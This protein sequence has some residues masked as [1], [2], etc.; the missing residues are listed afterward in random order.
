MECKNDEP[1]VYWRIECEKLMGYITELQAENERL[2]AEL[3][4]ALEQR[5]MWMY[6][7]MNELGDNLTARIDQS[8][9]EEK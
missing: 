8:K 2:T 4:E 3:A 5:D 7:A 6:R 1:A 9:E